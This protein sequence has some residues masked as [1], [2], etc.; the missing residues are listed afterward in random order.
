MRYMRCKC[1]KRTGFTSSGFQ[2]CQ[3]CE[4]CGTTYSDHP[5]FHKPLQPHEWGEKF[6]QNTGKPYKVCTR[7]HKTDYESFRESKISE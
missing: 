5:D 1:G 2:D 6:N 3:G 4:E 7:C